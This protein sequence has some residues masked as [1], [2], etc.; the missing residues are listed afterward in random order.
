[1]IHISAIG[2]YLKRGQKG[3]EEIGRYFAESVKLSLQG[4]LKS[5]GRMSSRC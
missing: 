4:M 2:D 1:M 3:R 5:F